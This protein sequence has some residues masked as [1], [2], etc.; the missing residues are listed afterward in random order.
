MGQGTFARPGE[1]DLGK[2]TVI[3][4]GPNKAFEKVHSVPSFQA[5][6]N[7]PFRKPCTPLMLLK[8]RQSDFFS[9]LKKKMQTF[10]LRAIEAPS[11]VLEPHP[12]GEKQAQEEAGCER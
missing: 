5:A 10:I 3:P 8:P 4:R 1:D 9:A 11:C 2:T 7:L 12:S 6:T